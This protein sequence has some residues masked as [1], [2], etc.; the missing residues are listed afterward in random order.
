MTT[1]FPTISRLQRLPESMPP[2]GSVNIVL[3]DGVPIFRASTTVLERINALLASARDKGLTAAEDAELESYAA[4]D[5]YLS[6]V[7]RAIRDVILAS[8]DAA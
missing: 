2:E 8:P 1:Q 5:D 7:N 6:F 4:I 3:E